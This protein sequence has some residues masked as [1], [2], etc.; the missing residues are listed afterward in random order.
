[1]TIDN[2]ILMAAKAISEAETILITAGAGMGVDSGLPDF[3]G[4]QGFWKIHPKYAEEGLT[5]ADLANP[6]W[7]ETLP[8]RAW[9]FYGYRYNLYRQTKPHC[10]FEILKKWQ[11]SSINP[12]FVYT[13][14]VDGHFQKA[15]FESE[16]IFEVHGS[17]N[18][19]QCSAKCRG[20]I[21]PA[22]DLKFDIDEVE[23]L[24]MGTL[25]LCPDCGKI[26][27]PNILMF[28][29]FDWL[30]SRSEQ[31]KKRYY[32]W[33]H[34]V[35]SSKKVV[36]EI[37]AG[38]TVGGIRFTSNSFS[39]TLI[40]INPRDA[41]GPEGTISIAMPALAALTAIDEALR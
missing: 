28:G 3:R 2:S 17:I 29:D 18:H 26:A 41:Q 34:S 9:G 14:N 40:R 25:P 21:W 36:I 24:A 22:S 12:G 31:Q 5:F 32:Q 11:D 20:K 15:G 27:R 7:F 37:G 19:L 8:S 16:R 10:G 35:A 39:G 23:L 6:V 33:R 4:N 38:F 30:A 1:M 13:S